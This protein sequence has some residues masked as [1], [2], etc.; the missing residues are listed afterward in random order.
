MPKVPEYRFTI[1]DCTPETTPMLR[2]GKY[3][4]SLARLFGHTKHVHFAHLGRGSIALRTTVAPSV[5]HEVQNRLQSIMGGDP[6]QDAIRPLREIKDLLHGDRSSGLLQAVQN[7]SAKTVIEFPRMDQQP[8]TYTVREVSEVAGQLIRIGGEREDYVP[9]HL[10]DGERTHIC[11]ADRQTAKE[12][13]RHLYGQT[14]RA[15][16]EG[17]WK[18]DPEEGWSLDQFRILAFAPLSD[19]PLDAIVT[20]LQDVKGNGWMDV[21]DPI[22]EVLRLR[23]PD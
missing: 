5:A 14:L 6:P 20:R 9:V 7:G 22:A 21:E 2:I 15:Q 12:M 10:K 23:N 4:E 18:R 19:E 16:G 3:I 13:A 8:T 1:A 17:K 11:E